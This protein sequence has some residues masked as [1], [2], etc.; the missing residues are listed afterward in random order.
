MGALQYGAAAVSM[1]LQA[2]SMGLM[3]HQM[4]GFDEDVIRKEFNIP[5]QYIPM[6]IMAIGYES[7]AEAA[8]V[9]E[10][11]RQPLNTNFFIGS[12]GKGLEPQ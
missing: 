2:T 5:L 12:W 11:V 9:P 3:A 8:K 7:A 6:S 10:K 1:A 4:G